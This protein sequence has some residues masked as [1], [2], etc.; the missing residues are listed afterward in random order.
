MTGTQ[1]ADLIGINFSTIDRSLK[2]ASDTRLNLVL[3]SHKRAGQTGGDIPVFSKAR[4]TQQLQS[5]KAAF[6][7]GKNRRGPKITELTIKQ[8][9]RLI[10]CS[11]TAIRSALDDPKDDRLTA[12]LLPQRRVSQRKEIPVFH[13]GT[14]TRDIVAIQESFGFGGKRI[15]PQPGEM[16]AAA[17]A[18][19]IG[20]T[21]NTVI[22]SL[23]NDGRLDDYVLPHKRAVGKLDV[24]VFDEEKVLRDIETIRSKFGKA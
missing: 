18:T 8:L 15:R 4:V 16:Q 9:R 7:K 23:E 2:R 22:H 5:L 20:C 21:R 17:L 24:P 11:E 1:L 12:Y 6:G 14:V 13:K 19:L 10:G 3:L